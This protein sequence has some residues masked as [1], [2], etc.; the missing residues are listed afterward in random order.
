MSWRNYISLCFVFLCAHTWLWGQEGCEQVG[1]I[2]R[3]V[4]SEPDGS[5]G[6][7]TVIKWSEPADLPDNATGYIIYKFLGPPFCQE[8]LVRVGLN[9]TSATLPGLAALGYTMALST[10]I[11]REPLTRRHRAPEIT[12]VR[13]DSCYYN[14]TIRW[15]PYIGWETADTEYELHCIIDGGEDKVIAV[16]L[17]DT[18]Y[19][20]ND[21]PSKALPLAI[22]V[23]ALNK[24]DPGAFGHS[25]RWEGR[26]DFPPKPEYLTIRAIDYKEEEAQLSFKIDPATEL[27][28]FELQRTAG[29]DF[30][31]VY[32]FSDKSLT[33]YTD[34]PPGGAQQYRLVAVSACGQAV[35]QGDTLSLIALSL[36]QEGSQWALRWESVNTGSIL[37][38]LDRVRP[39]AERLLAGSGET[40]FADKVDYDIDSLQFCYTVGGRTGN[41]RESRSQQCAWYAPKVSMPDAVDPAGTERNV[42][43]GRARNQFGP[44]VAADPKTYSYHL[45]IINRNAAVVA[46]IYKEKDEDPLAPGK[47]WD[48]RLKNGQPAPDDVYSYRLTV[49][50]DGGG[51]Q[52]MTGIVTV[53][54][55]TN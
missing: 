26:S 15:K 49:R 40:S 44:V 38:D 3:S 53:M 11:G 5:G 48:G 51:Q 47:S 12:A 31:T 27:N 9:T 46:D 4:S 23:R 1:N 14:A 16:A 32:T 18:V 24:K 28:R 6:Y 42:Q 52:V 34:R 25:R 43:T 54:Y 37:Y 8:E 10:D 30:S 2:I 41:G 7:N 45:N 17:T 39:D 50:F 21:A 36:V 19:V 55:S 33:S 22:Y 13:F 20:W 29:A 35:K